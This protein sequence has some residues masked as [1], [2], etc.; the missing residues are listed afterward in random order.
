MEN[1]LFPYQNAP[2]LYGLIENSPACV[3]GH[4]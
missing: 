2:F 4:I 1:N 3:F